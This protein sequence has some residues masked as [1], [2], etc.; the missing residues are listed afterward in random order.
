MIEYT[1]SDNSTPAQVRDALEHEVAR[2]LGVVNNTRTRTKVEDARRRGEQNAY[3]SVLDLLRNL[4]FVPP[5]LRSD[6][7]EKRA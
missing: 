7:L 4:K 1:M 6:Q 5:V 2:R 3:E